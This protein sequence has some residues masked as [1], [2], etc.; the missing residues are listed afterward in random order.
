[1]FPVWELSEEERKDRLAEALVLSDAMRDHKTGIGMQ[2]E[3]TLHSVLKFYVEP[4]VDWQEIP[5]NGYIA[6]IYHH[7]PKEAVE[8]QTGSFGPLREKLAAFLPEFP[9]T[10]VHPIVRKS[11]VWWVDPGTGELSGSGRTVNRKG[12]LYHILPELYRI[13]GALSLTGLRFLPILVDV[14]EYRIADG[15]SRDGKRG[16]HRADRLPTAV[17]ESVLL[18]KA[19]DF[20]RILPELP[21]IFTSEDFGKCTRFRGRALSYSMIALRTL[22]VAELAGKK[23]KKYLY[24]LVG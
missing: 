7:E 14:E 23:G 22:G 21:E 11:K 8:I 12:E 10:V 5:V 6:D 16:A 13:S 3:R 2:S 9:V 24:R 18:E 1:M 4:D 20:R 17:G 15:W 19:S